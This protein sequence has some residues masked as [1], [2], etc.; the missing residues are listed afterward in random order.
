M[1]DLLRDLPMKRIG[2][3]DEI[4]GAVLWLCSSG[5]SFVT[6]KALLVDGGFT[7]Q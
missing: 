4:A 6:G 3:G 1:D 2:A 7:A 5:S